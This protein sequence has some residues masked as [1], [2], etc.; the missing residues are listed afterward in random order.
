[1]YILGISCF[2]HESAACLIHDG[3]IVAASAE[4]RF[5]RI[6]HD[7]DFP[8]KAVAFCLETAG[9]RVEDIDHVVFYE[10]PFWKF[11]RI[12]FST[13]A[14]Y[15]WAM[16]LFAKA[17]TTWLTDKL[18][19]RS[20]LADQLN[21][22]PAKILFVPHHISHAAASFYPSGFKKAAILTVDGVGEWT[23]TTMGTGEGKNIKIFSEMRFP[24]SLGLLYSTFTAF[25][26]FEVNDGEYKVMGMA[27]YDKPIYLEQVRKL[28]D[29][30]P[31]GSFH[32]KME[33]FSFH[34]SADTSYS[35]KFLQLFGAPRPPGKYF[36]TTESGYP[37]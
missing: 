19:T 12:L 32:L 28:V 20:I 7:S 16:T 36:F 31:D 5:T 29:V 26:G 25:L 23:T 27:P 35:K 18:W 4:E 37:I 24:H 6:K 30:Y 2:Y 17:M 8:T 33:Y 21:I 13:L 9:I 1:M 3:K 11:H 34:R 22:S 10:K 15:P 14:S